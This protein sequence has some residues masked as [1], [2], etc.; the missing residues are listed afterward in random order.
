MKR[1]FG[2]ML[3][4]A[5]ACGEPTGTMP[6]RFVAR[7]AAGAVGESPL[8]VA[9]K[10]ATSQRTLEADTVSFNPDGTALRTTVVRL[11]NFSPPREFLFVTRTPYT[12]QVDGKAITLTPACG[13]EEGCF[14][15]ISG[16]ITEDQLRLPSSLLGLDLGRMFLNRIE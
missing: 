8:P 7:Y 13:P 4:L 6:G 5:T 2:A 9:I 16:E 14:G 11:N 10:L 15:P 1:T 12:Y 3:F